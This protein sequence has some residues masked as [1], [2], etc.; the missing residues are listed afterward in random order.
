M[1]GENKLGFLDIL[2]ITAMIAAFMGDIA[3]IFALGVVIPVIGLVILAVVLAA[4]YMAGLMVAALVIP[5]LNGLIPKLILVIGIILPLPTLLISII[6]AIIFQSEIVQTVAIAAV[7]VATGGA[8]AVAARGVS[9]AAE[10][11]EG[12]VVGAEG[13]GVAKTAAGAGR[14]AIAEGEAAE[15]E[16]AEKSET[17][18]AEKEVSPEE[19]GEE[20]EP[21][22]KLQK[23]LLE[24]TPSGGTSEEKNKDEDDENV[25]EDGNEIDLR[26]TGTSKSPSWAY[27]KNAVEASKLANERMEAAKRLG[28]DENKAAKK[29]FD[30]GEEEAKKRREANLKGS[31]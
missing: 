25:Y 26:R 19:L 30:L 12:G 8:G 13:A 21:M 15:G 23:R 29:I 3:F 14:G 16:A 18:R 20:P 6:L 7:G 4:H 2:A 17:G 27:D 11:A 1:N 5:K 22:E 24:E 31:I 9:V 10:A 28:M